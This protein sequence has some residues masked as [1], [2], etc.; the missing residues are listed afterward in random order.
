MIVATSSSY[1]WHLDPSIHLSPHLYRISHHIPIADGFTTVTTFSRGT[2]QARSMNPSATSAW[3]LRIIPPPRRLSRTWPTDSW[4]GEERLNGTKLWWCFVWSYEK[5]R[6]GLNQPIPL[7]RVDSIWFKRQN[8]LLQ[9][10]IMGISKTKWG[11]NRN[12]WDW[13]D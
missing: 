2:S 12:I 6:L 3:R 1:N 9:P 4:W 8:C 10:T 11:S 13:T 7:Q 5:R